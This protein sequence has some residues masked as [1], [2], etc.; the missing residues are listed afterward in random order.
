M[1][2]PVE[3]APEGITCEEL[4]AA[5]DQLLALVD[6]HLPQRFYRGVR[7]TP[8]DGDHATG[9]SSLRRVRVH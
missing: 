6:P 3:R 4:R 2:Q 8:G 5:V 9:T 7:V 1:E